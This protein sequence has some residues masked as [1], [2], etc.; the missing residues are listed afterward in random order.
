MRSKILYAILAFAQPIVGWGDVGHRTVGYLAQKYFTDQASQWVDNLLA[1]ENEY[2]ISDAAVW[3]DAVRYHRHY[4]E[5]WHFVDANDNPPESCGV[6]YKRDCVNGCVISAITNQTSIV[7]DHS[8]STT[9]Q[10]EALMYILHF[11]GDIHQPLHAEKLDRGG[12]E[13]KVCFDNRC[14]KENLHSI[15]D[16]DIIHKIN[17]LKHTEK[18]NQEK[19]AAAKWASQLYSGNQEKGVTSTAEECDNIQDPES[20]SVQWATETNAYVCSYVLANGIDWLKNNDLGGDYYDGAV[21]IVESQISK[22]GL[23]LAAWVNALA[24]AAGSDSGF[25]VQ[26]GRVDL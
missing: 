22:A 7:L 8:Q 13:I 18:H 15:W 11:I 4:T 14:S 16:T 26:R 19:D 12:N 2:D 17:G 21:P 3:A 24:A 10:T 5:G 6:N 9:V 1:N 25:T 20:C 23:R